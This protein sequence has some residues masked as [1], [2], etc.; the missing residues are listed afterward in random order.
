MN[1]AA[2]SRQTMTACFS[3]LRLLAIAV[4]ALSVGA[5]TRNSAGAQSSDAR[6]WYPWA[7]GSAG[8]G[9]IDVSAGS[10]DVGG[11]GEISAGV[12]TQRSLAVGV[13]LLRWSSVNLLS[14]EGGWSGTTVVG[15]A[16][17]AI[18]NASALHLIGGI[19]ASRVHRASS[20]GGALNLSTNVGETGV[21]ILT[22]SEQRL[23]IRLYAL[24][25]WNLRTR[26]D[27]LR[28]G[29]G[30]NQWYVGAGLRVR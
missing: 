15:F 6:G 7:A 5:A 14:D 17:L 20:T 12:S 26:D 4:A 23:G 11:F 10:A 30:G 22:R 3:G 9:A 24:R 29:Y 16:S 18:P 28:L 21:E 25:E 2:T 27:E 19:G 8:V 13:R 1:V